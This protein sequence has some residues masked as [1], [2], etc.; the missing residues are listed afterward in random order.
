[1]KTVRT[2]RLYFKKGA[3][4]KVYEVDLCDVSSRANPDQF[5]VNFRHGRR[6]SALR[7]GTKTPAPVARAKA[8]KIFDSL[9]V[10]KLNKGYQ[11]AEAVRQHS[12]PVPHESD[13]GDNPPDNE[14]Y[15]YA[16]VRVKTG[17]ADIA[18]R[19][20]DN[21]KA[22]RIVWRAGELGAFEFCVEIRV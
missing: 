19:Q 1:M 12:A 14:R 5:V 16:V 9:V 17:L 20:L 15:Q 22:S 8:V 21:K 10:S 6:G 7:E 4:D 13:A 2:S 18:S 11:D 3:S